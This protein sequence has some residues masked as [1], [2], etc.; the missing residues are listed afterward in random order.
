MTEVHSF[1]Q[2]FQFHF[3]FDLFLTLNPR[4]NFHYI[5]NLDFLNKGC[6]LLRLDDVFFINVGT[7]KRT[8]VVGR[9]YTFFQNA[10]ILQ[11]LHPWF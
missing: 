1:F 3:I 5:D 10:L 6:F 11:F 9:K 8:E 4:L 7:A 2:T